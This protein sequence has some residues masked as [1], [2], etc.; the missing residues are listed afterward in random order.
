[1]G[2]VQVEMDTLNVP[3]TTLD[4]YVAARAISQ[5]DIVKIDI[6]GA[7]LEAVKGAHQLLLRERSPIVICEFCD[8]T[9][10]TLG[11]STKKLRSAF[12]EMGFSLYRYDLQ[13]RKLFSEPR[14]DRYDYANLIC[15]K[16]RH[17]N[18]LAPELL[19]Q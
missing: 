16:D 9:T 6:E 17:K 1:M 2:G 12:E 3:C 5:V 13:T 14:Q 15:L 7:E 8:L 10:S 18:N 19:F 4:S 11:Y